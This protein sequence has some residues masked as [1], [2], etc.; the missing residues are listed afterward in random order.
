[1]KTKF[2]FLLAAMLLSASAFA[3][4]GNN[5]PLKGDVNGDGKVDVADINAI[6]KI[7]K[8]G[9]GTSEETIY[10]SYVGTDTSSKLVDI[11]TGAL[12]SDIATQ[13][14]TMSGVK[15]YTSIPSSLTTG[16]TI[17]ANSYVYVIAPTST[18]NNATTYLVNQ[19]NMNI[20]TET[21][22]TFTI[23]SIEYTVKSTPSEASTVV[24][25]W[26]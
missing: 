18:L 11:D 19:S 21:L 6:I 15:T 10:Y 14:K 25:A 16:E 9:G 8:D 22:G 7:M 23:E 4:S 24:T 1:M 12:K 26:K 3:Q 13:I 2:F 17:V 5:E 20:A